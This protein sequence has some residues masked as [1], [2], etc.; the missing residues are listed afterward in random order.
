LDLSQIDIQVY[1][2]LATKGPVKARNIINNLTINKRQIY[3]SLKRLQ[4]KGIT[5]RNNEFSSEFSVVPFEKLL[6]LL[7]ELKKEEAKSLQTSKEELILDFRAEKKN[8]MPTID[9]N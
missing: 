9:S 4:N 3:R 1:I 2:Y 7:L 5:M 8:P 6:D